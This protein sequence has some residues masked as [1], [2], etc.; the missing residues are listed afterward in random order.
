MKEKEKKKQKKKKNVDSDS[1]PA[2]PPQDLGINSF[3]R[4]QRLQ[5]PSERKIFFRHYYVFS[6]LRVSIH[7]FLSVYCFYLFLSIQASIYRLLTTC[8]CLRLSMY[9]FTSV[10]LSLHIRAST[11]LCLFMHLSFCLSM[12]LSIFVYLFTFIYP[13]L[14]TYLST[15]SLPSIYNYSSIYLPTLI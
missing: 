2:S 6:C 12:H 7:I 11:Y 5:I 4:R 9:I 15:S 3:Q 1:H 8:P 13:S 10:Y 14:P